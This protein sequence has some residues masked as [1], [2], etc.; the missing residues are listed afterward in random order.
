MNPTELTVIGEQH[1]RELLHLCNY[2]R[3][4]AR[5]RLNH[6]GFAVS[7]LSQPHHEHLQEACDICLNEGW[8]EEEDMEGYKSFFIT[9][10][11]RIRLRKSLQHTFEH[12]GPEKPEENEESHHDDKE[13]NLPA[14]GVDV[15]PEDTAVATTEED[16]GEESHGHE[17]ENN[18][19]NSSP[20]ESGET[21]DEVILTPPASESTSVTETETDLSPDESGQSPK[22]D[23]SPYLGLKV[24]EDVQKV[25]REGYPGKVVTFKKGTKEWKL[26]LYLIK[27]G[28]VGYTWD[29][30]AGKRQ[31]VDRVK[32]KLQVLGVDVIIH[33]KDLVRLE[34]I[35]KR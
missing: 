35:H 24:D 33:R 11:G 28:P 7:L 12:L 22:Q 32:T 23:D 1:I 9:R 10:K 4:D 17:E 20:N 16:A 27:T 26:F 18:E 2:S 34:L 6:Y 31:C 29:L 19:N 15:L 14:T 3:E 25:T 30:G 8:I 21:P 13:N 5:D